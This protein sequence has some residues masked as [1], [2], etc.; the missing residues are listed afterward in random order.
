[1]FFIHDFSRIFIHSGLTEKRTPQYKPH[2]EPQIYVRCIIFTA[3]ILLKLQCSK[4]N[5][6][7]IIAIFLLFKREK[8]KVFNGFGGNFSI[9]KRLY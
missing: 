3:F 9:K 7:A 1:M 8:L 5:L 4:K 2:F 6:Y